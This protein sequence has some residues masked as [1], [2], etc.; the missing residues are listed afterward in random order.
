MTTRNGPNATPL[1]RGCVPY[2]IIIIRLERWF[3]GEIIGEE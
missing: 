1:G 3:M 2:R